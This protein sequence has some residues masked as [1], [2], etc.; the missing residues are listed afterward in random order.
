[1][2]SDRCAAVPVFG[3]STPAFLSGAS[4]KPISALAV[5]RWPLQVAWPKFL[6]ERRDPCVVVIGFTRPPFC[7]RKRTVFCTA[8]DRRCN[9][10]ER[11][12][13]HVAA[14]ISARRVQFRYCRAAPMARTSA[15]HTAL[16]SVPIEEVQVVNSGKRGPSKTRK[17]S[18]IQRTPRVDAEASIDVSSDRRTLLVC[19]I[20][21]GLRFACLPSILRCCMS[22]LCKCPPRTASFLASSRP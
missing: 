8:E 11:D 13:L 10:R 2:A 14:A 4:F 3:F 22:S 9:S 6:V 19:N 12:V 16:S 20:S 1:M 21:D 17:E 18:G 7:P 15:N 5:E